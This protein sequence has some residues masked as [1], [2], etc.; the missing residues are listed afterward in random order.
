MTITG[1]NFGALPSAITVFVDG[2]SCSPV[3]IIQN[4]TII[5]CTVG[6]GYGAN[7]AVVVSVLGQFGYSNMSY[8]GKFLHN[9]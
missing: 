3:V 8:A 9:V 5:A 1:S 4:H 2:N 7:I 6:S